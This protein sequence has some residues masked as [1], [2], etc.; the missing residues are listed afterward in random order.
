MRMADPGKLRA[1]EGSAP[2][3]AAAVAAACRALA[4]VPPHTVVVFGSGV[5][6]AG[7]A[8]AEAWRAAGDARVVGCAAVGVLSGTTEHEAGRA[9]VALALGGGEPCLPFA[10]APP[11]LPVERGLALLFADAYSV[12]PAALV[13]TVAGAL[14]GWAV[15]GAVATGAESVRPAH[16]WLDGEVIDD[17]AAGL[18]VGEPAIIGVTEGCL[19]FGPEHRVTASEGLVIAELDG[20]PAFQVFA[21]RARPLLDD[22]PQAAQTV[23]VAEADA[24]GSGDGWDTFVLRGLL[25]FDPERGLLAT[26]ESIAPGGRI[27]FAMREPMAARASLRTMVER[28]RDALDGHTPRFGF[29]FDCAGR[30]SGLFGVAD[31]DVSFIQG[32]LGRF[33]MIGFLGGG[34]LAGARAHLFSGVLAVVP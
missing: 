24:P 28:V 1:A 22:L 26:S 23:F 15:A 14:P 9:A 30:G 4:P 6:D 5:A 11:A 33:P 29:Y 12:P 3:A 20:R 7:A 32:M 27:R 16:R 17:R 13:A 10:G 8:A 2:D 19:P 31:H 21:E 34:E 25:G 18:L